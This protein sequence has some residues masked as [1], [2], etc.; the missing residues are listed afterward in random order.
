MAIRWK[1][2]P[3]NKRYAVSDKGSVRNKKTRRVVRSH[4]NGRRYRR[5]QLCSDSGPK[6]YR[7]ARLV[8]FTFVGPPPL[9][10][11]EAAHKDGRRRNNALANLYWA[12]KEQNT[13]DRVRHHKERNCI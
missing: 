10:G 12:T 8:L 5:V 6:N 13:A 9:P 2:C 3:I 4:P 1:V 11:M 7:V